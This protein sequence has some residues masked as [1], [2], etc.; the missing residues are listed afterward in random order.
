MW[1]AAQNK[2]LFLQ[3]VEEIAFVLHKGGYNIIDKAAMHSLC[4]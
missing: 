2:V 3:L 1:P 4:F